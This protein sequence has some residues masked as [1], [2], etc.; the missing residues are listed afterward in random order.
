[1]NNHSRRILQMS[2]VVWTLVIA[3]KE[4]ASCWPNQVITQE[5]FRFYKCAVEIVHRDHRGRLAGRDHWYQGQ[6]CCRTFG[7][8]QANSGQMVADEMD[9]RKR[10]NCF[11]LHSMI[12][13]M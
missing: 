10:P 11:E 1:M 13:L 4:W 9:A 2:Q 6:Y 7:E 3:A 8:E 12:P 5:Q